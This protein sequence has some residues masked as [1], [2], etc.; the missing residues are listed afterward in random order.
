MMSNQEMLKFANYVY[1]FYGSGGIYDM[2]AP[3]EVIRQ[4]I[5]FLQTKDGREFR[6]GC[7]VCGDSVDREHIREILEKK[8]G[9]CEINAWHYT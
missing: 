6:K 3:I 4:A 9:F 7:P 2:G 1:S 5:R 8:Y